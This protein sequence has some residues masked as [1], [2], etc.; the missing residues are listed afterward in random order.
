MIVFVIVWIA[1]CLPVILYAD[2]NLHRDERMM[3]KVWKAGYAEK[4]AVLPNGTVINFGE[5]GAGNA[6]PLL[7][8][9]GQGQAWQDY[10]AV[11]PAL[12]QKY[13]VYALDCHGHGKSSHDPARY[14]CKAMTEDFL[15]FAENVIGAPCVVS[16]HSSGGILAANLAATGAG[17]IS[18]LLI[19]DAPFFCVEPE[20]MR[21]RNAIVWADGFQIMHDFLNQKETACYNEYY[22]RHSVLMGLFGNLRD[23]AADSAKRF[24]QKHPGKPLCIWYIPQSLLRG[25]Y[26]GHMY[27]LRFAETFYSGTWFDG[28]SQEDI[29]RGVSCP[30]T[31]IK[32]KTGYLV[33]GKITTET[34]ALDLTHAMLCCANT[35]AD[36]ERV[37]SLLPG[38]RSVVTESNDHLIHAK[39]PALFIRETEAF[40]A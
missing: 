25:M 22:M 14:S 17:A 31:Y 3:K 34:A 10:D 1:L 39:Y 4:Q 8:L 18:G 21:E 7:L 9:H 36:A 35:D 32:A 29:L 28:V 11:L 27:D 16:G 37:R 40:L 13:H 6:T 20:E 24:A 15:W 19:E 26:Y 23:K 33:D 5:G 12:A 2:R 38:C 30:C